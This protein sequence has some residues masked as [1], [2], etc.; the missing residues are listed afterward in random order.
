M[1][2]WPGLGAGG[3]GPGGSPRW[4]HDNGIMGASEWEEREEI[5]ELEGVDRGF[6]E[7]PG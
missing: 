5:R 1:A 7:A 3:Q 2:L 4:A 6:V